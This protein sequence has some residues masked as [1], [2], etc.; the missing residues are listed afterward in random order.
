MEAEGLNT[1]QCIVCVHEDAD[2]INSKVAKQEM[3]DEQA[4]KHFGISVRIWAAHYE[5]HVLRKLV[6]ALS[7]DIV[8]LKKIVINKVDMVSES[9]DRLRRVILEMN[10]KLLKREDGEVDSKDILA[11]GQMERNLAQTVKDLAHIQGELNTGDTI[12]IQN[13]VV[14]AEKL[15]NVVMENA[16]PACKRIFLDKLETVKLETNEE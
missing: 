13:N 3:T 4:A 2:Y 12:N 16:C 14:K 10:E 5:S 8:P 11:L 7:T 1:N 9:C 15:T 6:S